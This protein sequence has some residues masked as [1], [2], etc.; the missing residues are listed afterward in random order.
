M[1]VTKNNK[2]ISEIYRQ[3][4]IIWERSDNAYKRNQRQFFDTFVPIKI[5]LQTFDKF[6][7]LV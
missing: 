3:K 7:T 2:Y 5:C 6:V 4:I 1:S